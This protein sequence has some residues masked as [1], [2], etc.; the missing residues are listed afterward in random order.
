MSWAT[1]RN[2]KNKL[3]GQFVALP[4]AVLDSPNYKL[5]SPRRIKLLLDIAVQYNGKN[6]GDLQAAWRCMETRGWK[7]RDT[8]SKALRE[9][10]HYGFIEKTRQG[11][12]NKCSLFALTW[13]GIDFGDGK[14]DA[15]V[16]PN[17]VASGLWKQTRTKFLL[18]RKSARVQQEQNASTG[19][20]LKRHGSRA[21]EVPMVA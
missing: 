1:R 2:K 9:L 11:G 21:N 7:S 13:H 17:A 15:G 19:P 10:L 3:G 16:R 18:F 4:H 14:Y 12:L 8:L 20:E 5:L 6:N